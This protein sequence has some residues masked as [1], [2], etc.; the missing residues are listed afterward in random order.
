[1]SAGSHLAE[2]AEAAMAAT[3]AAAI[4]TREWIGGGD[5]HAADAAATA[6]MRSALSSFPAAA[7]VVVGEGEK[8]GAPMLSPGER[9]GAARA[10]PSTSRSTRSSARSTART[11]SPV[12]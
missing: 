5:G 9:L 11:G 7:T 4:A 1:M 12:R 6:A 2:L 10:R 3:R 8:D